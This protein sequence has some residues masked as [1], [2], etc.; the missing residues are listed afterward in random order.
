MKKIFRLLI[1]LVLALTLFGCKEKDPEVSYVLTVKSSAT[2]V[3]FNGTVQFSATVTPTP[4]EDVTFTWSVDDAQKGT[5]SDS[6][7]FTAKEVK[8]RVTITC[9][10]SNGLT[11]NKSITV[12]A[13]TGTGETPDLNGYTI[14]IA[15]AEHALGEYD[16]FIEKDQEATYGYY[17]SAD[18]EAKQQAWKSVE[19]DFNCFIDI[20]AYPA[21]APWGPSRWTYITNRAMID[22]P[23]YDFYVVPD[24]QISGFVNA[25]AL[26]D[27][28]DWYDK[29]GNNTMSSMSKTAATVQG[30][31]YSINTADMAIYNVLCYNYNLWKEINKADSSIEEPA[32]LFNDGKWS[33]SE[34]EAYCTKAQTVLNSLYPADTE[35]TA[36][37]KHYVLS[38]SPS[39]YWVGMLDRNGKGAT[40]LSNYKVDL[41]STD[42]TNAADT[43]KRIYAGGAMDPDYGVDQGVET[44]N[45]GKALFDTGDLWFVNAANRWNSTLWGEGTTAYGYV[46]FPAPDGYD[47]TRTFVGS[48][49]EACLVMAAG[50]EKVYDTYG[51]ETENVYQAFMEYWVRAKENYQGASDYDADTQIMQTAETKFGAS[52]ESM[53]AYI[54]VCRNI[55]TDGF[56]DPLVS[57]SNAVVNTWGSSF[58]QAIRAYINGTGAATWSDAIGSFQDQLNQA[59]L[60][61][62]G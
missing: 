38:G 6:G 35:E 13:E 53:K 1:V 26:V 5:I 44:W 25:K 9:T 28:T 33:Y 54:T 15:Q 49:S 10:A 46:P 30:R 31:L 17:S 19:E 60:K 56:Y 21:D 37:D 27:L 3:A 18:R 40:D 58:D 20:V 41:S 23:E 14:K 43:M 7:L 24:A 57:P 22:D 52:E 34:F 39:Y 11:G 29:Y 42:S 62:F 2:M 12:K 16:V 8:G 4:T 61:S 48:T 47:T 36:G 59:V 32:K 45:A 50:R 55:N 51:I